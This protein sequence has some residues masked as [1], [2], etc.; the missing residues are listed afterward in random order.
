MRTGSC[1]MG[2]WPLDDL[3]AEQQA[4]LVEVLEGCMADLDE[5]REPDMDRIAAEHPEL[6][7]PLAACLDSVNFLHRAALAFAST[8]T[9]EESP[10]D[11]VQRQIGDYRIVREIGRGGMGVVYEAQQTSLNR[12]VALKVLPFAARA[13]PAPNRAF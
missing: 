4:R 11:S 9:E 13:R 12:R 3:T 5:G 1:A 2:S 6:A 10:R 8:E 7:E